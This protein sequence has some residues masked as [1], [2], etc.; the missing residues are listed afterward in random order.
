MYWK[1]KKVQGRRWG[2]DR[3]FGT[4]MGW[5]KAGLGFWGAWK[6]GEEVGVGMCVEF[7]SVSLRGMD[8]SGLDWIGLD[9]EW[10]GGW[11]A[12]YS[13]ALVTR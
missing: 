3:V 4:G 5:A 12:G 1:C 13:M 6:W 8:W 9:G 11:R 10:D 2:R 7:G